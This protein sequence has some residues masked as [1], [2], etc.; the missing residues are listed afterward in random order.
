MKGSEKLINKFLTDKM[1]ITIEDC[2]RLLIAYGYEYRKRG[3]S[4]RVYHKK[5]ETP[6]TV[7]IPK[8]KKYIVS[9]YIKSIIKTL[10]LE[11]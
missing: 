8:R 7:P 3:G 11:E 9:P 1:H 5:G 2:D 6:I 10:G 4:H